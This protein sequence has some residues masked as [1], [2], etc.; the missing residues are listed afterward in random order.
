MTDTTA[1]AKAMERALGFLE[2]ARIQ[3][4]ERYATWWEAKDGLNFCSASDEEIALRAIVSAL[5]SDRVRA[6]EPTPAMIDAGVAFALQ[7]SL[8]GDYQWSQYVRDLYINMSAALTRTDDAGGFR[9]ISDPTVPDGMAKIVH[10][11]GRI[12]YLPFP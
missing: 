4:A 7:V 3:E 10:P 2:A 11:D 5:R 6:M 9:V 8:G 12:Q 1:A